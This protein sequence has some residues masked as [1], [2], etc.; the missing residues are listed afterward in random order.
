MTRN[1]YGHDFDDPQSQLSAIEMAWL[2]ADSTVPRC[3]HCNEERHLLPMPGTAWGVEVFHEPHC[4]NHEDNQPAAG[5]DC[6]D[7]LN[8]S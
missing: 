5:F 4:P 7:R 6:T 1:E 2:A 8:D 3:P